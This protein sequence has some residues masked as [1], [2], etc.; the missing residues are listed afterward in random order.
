MTNYLNYK[1]GI[2]PH[3]IA[4]QAGQVGSSSAANSSNSNMYN[5]I[6]HNQSSQNQ[7]LPYA[8][9]PASFPSQ[10]SFQ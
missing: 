7:R 3:L 8:N 1:N 5:A 4:G 2:R 9:V 6:S 10:V